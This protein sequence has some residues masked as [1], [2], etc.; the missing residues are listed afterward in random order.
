M[1]AISMACA[2]RDWNGPVYLTAIWPYEKPRFGLL[3]S[4][5]ELLI[6]A[7]ATCEVAG[8][9]ADRAGSLGTDGETCLARSANSRYRARN[10]LLAA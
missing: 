6:E 10:H 1:V 9:L 4:E 3:R 8:G 2:V 5:Y 7:G